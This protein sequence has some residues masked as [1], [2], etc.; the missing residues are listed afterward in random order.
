MGET[1]LPRNVDPQLSPDA[2]V[3]WIAPRKTLHLGDVLGERLATT[4]HLHEL[5]E[6]LDLPLSELSNCSL[7]AMEIPP[8]AIDKWETSYWL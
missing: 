7:A 6:H 3:L 1:S 8:V 5:L 2:S 4:Y